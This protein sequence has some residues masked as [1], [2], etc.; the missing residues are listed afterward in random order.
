MNPFTTPFTV[1]LLS[2]SA[3]KTLTPELHFT[4]AGNI[5]TPGPFVYVLVEPRG[6]IAYVGKSDAT[7]GKDGHRA[8]AY[9]KWTG[10]YLRD[11]ATSG[12]PDPLYDPFTGDLDLTNWSPIVRFAARNALIVKVASTKSTELSGRTWEA[13]IQALS[14][15]LTGLES[16]VGGSGW[17]ANNGTV[18]GDGYDWAIERIEEIRGETA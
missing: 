11:M 13:R 2:F 5:A 4:D 16:L 9:A 1:D 8:I 14:G 7:T 15:V 17:E 12:F 6:G 18:R 3:L 10:D